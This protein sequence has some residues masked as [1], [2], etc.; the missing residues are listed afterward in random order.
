MY[1]PMRSGT[2]SWLHGSPAADEERAW[3]SSEIA[4]ELESAA[5]VAPAPAR[6]LFAR[7]RA[8][9]VTAA[10]MLLAVLGI[11]AVLH[12]LALGLAD[13]DL[14]G[15]VRFGLDMIESRSLL[16]EDV[17]SYLTGGYRWINHELL[18]ELLFGLAYSAAGTTGLLALKFAVAVLIFAALFLY[19]SASGLTSL[20]ASAVLVPAGYLLWLGLATI[21]P[22]MFSILFLLC[23]ILLLVAVER[24]RHGAL[25]LVPLVFA[26]WINFHGGVLAGIGFLGVWCLVHMIARPRSATAMVVV[27][28]ASVV[29]TL[30]T[31]YGPELLIF[32]V[33]TATVPRPE[34]IEWA[35]LNV[36][37]FNGIAYLAVLCLCVLGWVF[38]NRRRSPSQL[39]VFIVAALLPLTAWRHLYLFA[40]AAPIVSA[41][42]IASAWDRWRPRTHHSPWL[43][44]ATLLGAVVFAFATVPDFQCIRVSDGRPYPVA[45]VAVL[46]ESGVTGNLAV[47]G[48]FWGEYV[49]WHLGPELKVSVDGRRETVYSSD[50]W[51]RS[52]AFATGRGKWDQVLRDPPPELVL[53][54][55]GL[56]SFNL[57][58]LHPDW[59]LL[60][61][62]ATSGIFGREGS[63]SA[64][65]VRRAAAIAPGPLPTCFP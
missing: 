29:A 17:Y 64:A 35:P 5:P 26:A 65:A 23:L 3:R 14:W 63:P 59:V 21:R 6:S 11:G 62:D 1:D 41:E 25:L 57:M 34:V 22:Q 44:G 52:M 42:H 54:A 27:G 60:Y 15:H 13:P 31:P 32:L 4:S 28:L 58:S 46:R 9:A 33:R 37:S 47:D 20:R 8:A 55:S 16:H 61:S 51:S 24:G 30:I 53:A 48:F 56:P 39:A 38:S 49:L 50:V 12:F 10:G 19:L 18:S 36:A 2:Q 43:S 40:V 7:L 45:S